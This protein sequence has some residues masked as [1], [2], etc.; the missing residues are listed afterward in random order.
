MVTLYVK[1]KEEVQKLADSD[2]SFLDKM[3][4]DEEIISLMK[5]QITNENENYIEEREVY[6]TYCFPNCS[7][8]YCG[9]NSCTS[10][11]TIL[12]A[13]RSVENEAITK[14]LKKKGATLNINLYFDFF[15]Q[16]GFEKCKQLI[17]YFCIN[18]SIVDRLSDEQVVSIYKAF[19]TACLCEEQFRYGVLL[20][21]RLR[22]LI[23][24]NKYTK[25]IK[26]K[27]EITKLFNGAKTFIDKYDTESLTVGSGDLKYI[28]ENCNLSKCE[29]PRYLSCFL[30]FNQKQINDEIRKILFNKLQK[31]DDYEF[32]RVI[33]CTPD[34][35]SCTYLCF[36]DVFNEKQLNAICCRLYNIIG[37]KKSSRDETRYKEKY[38]FVSAINKYWNSSSKE[39]QEISII[40]EIIKEMIELGSDKHEVRFRVRLIHELIGDKKVI[41]GKCNFQ[42]IYDLMKKDPKFLYAILDIYPNCDYKFSFIKDNIIDGIGEIEILKLLDKNLNSENA[43]NLAEEIK[44]AYQIIKNII[45]FKE[46]FENEELIKELLNK[47]FVKQNEQLEQLEGD[48]LYFFTLEF[49]E[50]NLF[51]YLTY[52]NK[53]KVLENFS[54]CECHSY[55]KLVCLIIRGHIKINQ[56]MYLWEYLF[57]N[58]NRF[59]LIDALFKK[60]D[61]NGLPESFV[62]V[63]N[64]YL[65]DNKLDYVRFVSKNS[66]RRWTDLEISYICETESIDNIYFYLKEEWRFTEQQWD[67]LFKYFYKVKSNPFIPFWVKDVYYREFDKEYKIIINRKK[68]L[69]GDLIGVKEKSKINR[70]VK[71]IK[72]K[73]AIDEATLENEPGPFD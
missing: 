32:Q 46:G 24:E 34:I 10:I 28:V 20:S 45:Y 50:E 73:A 54:L 69:D 57:K 31:L 56:L 44:Q 16:T 63:L 6:Y 72:K 70:L 35:T 67:R 8:R 68:Y 64:K 60:N 49:L 27:E 37:E 17:S 71:S 48:Q 2:R 4:D 65:N 33:Y 5:N 29:Y 59:G 14:H 55:D 22:K 7:D 51:K 66:G 40:N 47:V 15:K 3:R 61:Y 53:N 11:A 18:P 1:N 26:K 62:N 12:P 19:P 25:E 38:A 43:S 30:Q 42:K 21:R 41:F 58:K 52:E 23:L 39:K 36:Y 9:R 13:V